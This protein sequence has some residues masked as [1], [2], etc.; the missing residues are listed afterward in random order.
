MVGVAQGEGA[1]GAIMIEQQSP[2]W[3]A[4]RL[5]K[6]TGSKMGDLLATTKSG[7]AASRANYLAQLVCERLTGKKADTFVSS[8]MQRGTDLEP[9][10]RAA[11]EAATGEIVLAAEFVTHPDN[12]DVGASPDGTVGS[13]GL[14]EIKC[15]NAAN[16]I[17]ALRE[18]MASKYRPQVQTQLW[19]TGREWCD[20]CVYHPDFPES[21]QLGITRVKADTEYHKMLQ[22]ETAKFLAEVNVTVKELLAKFGQKEAA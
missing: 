3:F 6:V 4:Q 2:E 18:G 21:M 17:D 20:F 11:Y 7:P 8:D 10:A 13:T 22:L 12:P 14:L 9:F 16:H 1:E 5:G 19:V 15:L